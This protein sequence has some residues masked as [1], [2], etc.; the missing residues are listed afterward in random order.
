MFPMPRCESC[1]SRS[2]CEATG[3][4]RPEYPRCRLPLRDVD[5]G[6]TSALLDWLSSSAGVGSATASALHA[7]LLTRY[8]TDRHERPDVLEPSFSCD[9]SGAHLYR[10]SYGFPTL[11]RERAAV[12]RVLLDVCQPLG[13]HVIEAARTVLRAARSQAV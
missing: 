6:R 3:T 11:R 7:P 5:L 10:F 2:T 4:L 1:S 13:S 12:E 8:A 9:A